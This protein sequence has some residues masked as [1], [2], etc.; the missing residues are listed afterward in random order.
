VQ[1][2]PNRAMGRQNM[3]L[4]SETKKIKETIDMTGERIYLVKPKKS[5]N[6]Y[7]TYLHTLTIFT[8]SFFICFASFIKDIS[9]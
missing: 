8:A 9:G 7:C 6:K 2:A 3:D 5:N 1:V 4:F